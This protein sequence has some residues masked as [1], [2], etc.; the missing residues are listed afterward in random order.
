MPAN[1]IEWV[2]PRCAKRLAAVS[3]HKADK[4]SISG[5]LWPKAPKNIALLPSFLPAIASPIQAPTAICVNESM[6]IGF[7]MNRMEL[8][9]TSNFYI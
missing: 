9:P 3:F 1:K 5:M 8:V 6:V 4:K 2:K 7:V